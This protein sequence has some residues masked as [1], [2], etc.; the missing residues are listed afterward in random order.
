MTNCDGSSIP[1]R[2]T[3]KPKAISVRSLEQFGGREVAYQ[4]GTKGGTPAPA[5]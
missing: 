2:L 5:V 3:G 1:K 4:M